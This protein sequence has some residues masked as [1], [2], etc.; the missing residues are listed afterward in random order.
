MP[1]HSFEPKGTISRAL[2]SDPDGEAKLLVHR[3]PMVA[4]LSVKYEK[5]STYMT[6]H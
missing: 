1:S 5:T 6:P 3:S 2:S 4:N